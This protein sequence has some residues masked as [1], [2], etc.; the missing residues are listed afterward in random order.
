MNFRDYIMLEYIEYINYDKPHLSVWLEFTRQA[1]YEYM[2]LGEFE[3]LRQWLLSR[4][5]CMPVPVTANTS[6]KV[7]REFLKEVKKEKKYNLF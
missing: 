2:E 4:P 1:P 6:H 3:A 7:A 5:E